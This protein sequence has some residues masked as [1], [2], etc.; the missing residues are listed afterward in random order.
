MVTVTLEGKIKGT[1]KDL[2]ERVA[3]EEGSSGRLVGSSAG[4]RIDQHQL[5]KHDNSPPSTRPQIPH[6]ELRRQVILMNCASRRY[7]K[8]PLRYYPGR[9]A[10]SEQRGAAGDLH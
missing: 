1:R 8:R 5:S 6:A 9:E 7:P 2:H 10:L 4:E 3:K